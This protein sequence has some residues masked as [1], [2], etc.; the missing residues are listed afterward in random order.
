MVGSILEK[1]QSGAA[2][3][4]LGLSGDVRELIADELFPESFQYLHPVLFSQVLRAESPARSA[5]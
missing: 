4:H 2:G 1:Y 3:S 5:K